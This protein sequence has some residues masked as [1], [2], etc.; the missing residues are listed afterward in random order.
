MTEDQFGSFVLLG[1]ENGVVWLQ[2]G[3]NH[4]QGVASDRHHEAFGAQLK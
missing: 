1:T 3:L 4:F 2:S